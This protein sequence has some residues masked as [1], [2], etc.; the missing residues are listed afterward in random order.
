MVNCMSDTFPAFLAVSCFSSAYV[1][2]GDLYIVVYLYLF[3][4]A[5]VSYLAFTT[6]RPYKL[7]MGSN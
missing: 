3:G 5:S 7:M 6:L 4:M 2:N 1:R